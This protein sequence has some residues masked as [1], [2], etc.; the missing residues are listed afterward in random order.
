VSEPTSGRAPA[1]IARVH[2][3]CRA[4]VAVVEELLARRRR[5][6]AP[7][8]GEGEWWPRSWHRTELED[9]VYSSYRQMRQGRVTRPPRRE[10]VMEI[11]SY[12]SCT[13]AERNRLLLAAHAAPISPYLTGERLDELLPVAV[14]VAARLSIPAMVINRDWRVHYQNAQMLESFAITPEQLASIRPEQR[15]VL[16]LLFDPALPLRPN[17]APYPESWQR[18]ARQSIYG[19][20]LA[21]QLCQHEP[22]YLDLVDRLMGLPDFADHWRSVQPDASFDSDP[23]ALARSP[24]VTVDVALARPEPGASHARLRPLVVSIGYFQFDFPLVLA[25]LPVESPPI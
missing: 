23:S 22:W 9:T 8:S 15:N 25:F 4:F 18:M 12:L 11:A 5:E 16:Q 20:K 10:V 1:W 6:Q 17:L 14:E 3:E 24:A 21:N 2:P 13:L 19:F 7:D